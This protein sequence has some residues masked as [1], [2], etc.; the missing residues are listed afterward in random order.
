MT[1]TQQQMASLDNF[2]PLLD[3]RA[4]LYSA[5]KRI[6]ERIKELDEE[7]RPVLMDRGAVIWN[8]YE[9]DVKS[10]QGR[11]TYDYKKMIEDGIDLGPYKKI[12]APS[13]RFTVK[14]VQ[15]LG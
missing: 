10:V 11:T 13:T 1:S 7:L 15:E 12:G 6:E 3:E 4:D 9:F 8:G 5:K 2:K 14:P